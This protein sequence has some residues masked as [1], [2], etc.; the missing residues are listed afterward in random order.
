MPESQAHKT[1][2]VS[3]AI[4][5]VNDKAHL[6]HALEFIQADVLARYHR[7]HGDEVCFVTGV[8]EHGT[9]IFRA[10]EAASKTPK[11]FV[12]AVSQTFIDIKP[13][14]GLSYDVFVRTSSDEHKKAAQAMWKACAKDIYKA[15]YTGL[16]CVGCETFYTEKDLLKGNLCPIHKTPVE[17]VSEENYFFKLS[18]YTDQVKKLVESDAYKVVPASRKNEILKV[19][20]GGLEDISISRSHKK[21]PW[22]VP[23]PGD[24][25]Q[26]MW[27]WFD[28]L[29][30]Y[31]SA[32]GYPDGKAFKKFWPANVHVVGKDILRFHAAIWPAMLLSAGLQ[33]PKTL[34]VHGFISIAG[35][36]MSKTTGNVVDPL[37]AVEKYG[38]DAFRYYLMRE[39]PSDSDG[40]FSWQRF[41]SVYLA[42]LANDLGNL[43]QRTAAMIT[44]YFD[45]KLGAVPAHAHDTTVY[46]DALANFRFDDALADVWERVRGLNQLIEEEKPWVSAKTD[47]P[48]T[49]EILTHLVADLLQVS[50]LLLPFLPDTAT[51]ITQT[52]GDGKVDMSVGILFPKLEHLDVTEVK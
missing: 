46:T 30:N 14:L 22:G 32:L 35:E 40:D 26:V 28:A 52:F 24:P 9:K 37:E 3:T 23:V 34:Y 38:L 2:Y 1:F 51:K 17:K 15:T 31:I 16:Y 39:I 5:Y 6:G 27:V 33:V 45:G 20:E 42:D 41:D 12:D 4:P 8:D 44:K 47:L 49:K 13:K 36:K 7:Q 29:P 21:L 50:D 43:V 11:Q 48:H 25:T 19:L 18:N 10:A